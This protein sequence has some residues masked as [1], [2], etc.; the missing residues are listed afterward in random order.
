VR[1]GGDGNVG[2]WGDVGEGSITFASNDLVGWLG[3][4][5]GPGG[6]V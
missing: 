4:G 6:K 1:L 2:S 5:V 3:V